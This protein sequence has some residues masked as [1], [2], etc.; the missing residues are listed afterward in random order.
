MLTLGRCFE[1]KGGLAAADLSAGWDARANPSFAQGR[2]QKAEV[3][4]TEANV[5]CGLKYFRV[6]PVWVS[7]IVIVYSTLERAPKNAQKCPLTGRPSMTFTT[8]STLSGEKKKNP[9]VLV[10]MTS[11][12]AFQDT[13][14]R[15][16]Q[17]ALT[18]N[19]P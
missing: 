5:P 12:Y 15:G 9:A 14:A 4:A 18:A 3:S 19:R 1:R 17:S 10:V 16:D 11:G 6:V 2:D 7:V 13:P 8:S